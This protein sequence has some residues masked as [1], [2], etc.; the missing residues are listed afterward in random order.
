LKDIYCEK[1]KFGMKILFWLTHKSASWTN[2]GWKRVRQLNFGFIF[3]FNELKLNKILLVTRKPSFETTKNVLPFSNFKLYLLYNAR[4][5]HYPQRRPIKT[6]NLS[7]EN[8]QP[9]Y[10]FS[11]FYINHHLLLMLWKR[12]VPKFFTKNHLEQKY[13]ITQVVSLHDDAG[14]T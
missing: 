4:M 8:N 14:H 9:L 11:L 7:S 10:E 2:S 1:L 12:M 13:Y 5:T 6:Q 3:F